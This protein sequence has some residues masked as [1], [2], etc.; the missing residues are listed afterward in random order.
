MR[1]RCGKSAYIKVDGVADLARILE[2]LV[3]VRE[4]GRRDSQAA[5]ALDR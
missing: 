2:R 5:K 1:E 3:S 4:R